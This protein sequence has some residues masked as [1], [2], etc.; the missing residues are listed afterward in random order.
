MT[1]IPTTNRTAETPL[2]IAV[3]ISGG[4]TNL[5]ALID[6]CA[7]PVSPAA[8]PGRIVGVISNRPGAYGLERARLAGIP[9]RVIDH[10]AHPDRESFDAALGDALAEM[11]AELVCL[12]GFMRVL[13]SGF[14]NRFRWRL[15]NIH[16]SLLP[17]F[18]GLHVQQQALD[19]GVRFSGATVH[20][21]VPEV[22]AGPII[23]QAVVPVLPGD[24]ADRLAAR[25]LRQEH[26]IYP[27]A[28]R[29]FAEGRLRI[30][31]DGAVRVDGVAAPEA[32]LINPPAPTMTQ[33]TLHPIL[34]RDGIAVGSLSACRVLLMNDCRHPWLIL[35]PDRPGLRDLDELGDDDAPLVH[36]DIN[37]AARALRTLFKPDK[38]N[39]A[40]LGNV[41]P[42]L[43]VHVIA[44]F[45]S[46]DA[47]PKPVWGL[48]PPMP[49]SDSA[50]EALLV[51]L[52][53]ALGIPAP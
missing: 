51:R 13:T 24:D 44:R 34:A 35:V 28:V 26:R 41:V 25:I 40:A 8:I 7:D 17:A 48:H 6:A 23:V 20:F 50:R 10:R 5:Q 15:I 29:W 21:V 14:V 47:W 43:H 4:G 36:A 22:D 9:T 49:Y 30:Q 11:G 33:T 53:E 18:P 46:D 2:A 38:L 12:A 45:E 16:P 52:R 42:Q 27:L 3:L 1:E 39:I 19:A 32:A 37:R 31:D